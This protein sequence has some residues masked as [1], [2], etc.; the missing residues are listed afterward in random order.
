MHEHSKD[1]TPRSHLLKDSRPRL[2][3][4]STPEEYHH[5]VVAALVPEPVLELLLPYVLLLVVAVLVPR[6]VLGLLLPYVLLLVVAVLVPKPVL[7][8][9]LPYVLLLVVAVLVPRPVLELPLPY[10]LLLVVA[11]L[12]P[13]PVLVP[14]QV[15]LPLVQARQNCS[16]N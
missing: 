16:R 4:F 8:L 1:Y 7:E 2:P 9:L 10:V 15:R 5:R 13:R 11:V 6:P 14:V 3:I 12:V